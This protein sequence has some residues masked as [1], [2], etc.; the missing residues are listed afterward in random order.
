MLLAP[1]ISTDRL[2]IHQAVDLYA[3]H[4]S[5]SW[6][7]NMHYTQGQD[8][9]GPEVEEDEAQCP[10]AYCTIII[11]DQLVYRTRTKPLSNK[12]FFNAN[13]ERFVR[14]WRT[15]VCMV[16]VRD[17]RTREHDA[18][19][20]IV[21][22][23]LSEV[24]KN[25]S[26]VTK[27]YP[28]IGGVGEAKVRI[29]L[30][31]ESIDHTLDKKLLGWDVGNLRVTSDRFEALAHDGDCR[32]LKN[33]TLKMFTSL[34]S[35][36]VSR[37]LSH[38]Q[39]DVVYWNT[40]MAEN[41]HFELPIINRHSSALCI[42][43][44][45]TAR[46]SAYAISVLWLTEI[47]DNQKN[48]IKIPIWR[49]DTDQKRYQV[50]QNRVHGDQNIHDMKQIGY[51][52]FDAIFLRGLGAS[53]GKQ[54]SNDPNLRHVHECW[55]ATIAHGQRE[56]D[57][58]FLVGH[59]KD[60]NNKK[61]T[62]NIGADPYSQLNNEALDR[63]ARE[64][65]SRNDKSH[66]CDVE[67]QSTEVDQEG[68]RITEDTTRWAIAEIDT[69]EGIAHRAPSNTYSPITA[70]RRSDLPPNQRRSEDLA[71]MKPKDASGIDRPRPNSMYA[72]IGQNE[73][74]Q[75]QAM[76]DRWN[77][78]WLTENRMGSPISDDVKQSRYGSVVFRGPNTRH[79]SVLPDSISRSSSSS[80]ST[81]DA[82]SSSVRDVEKD[83]TVEQRRGK[84]DK[85]AEKRELHRQQRGSM[86]FK[87]MR[88]LKWAKDGVR[89][90]SAKFTDQFKMKSRQPDVQS[91]V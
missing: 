9:T 10:S 39:K 58:S 32:Q 61:R 36:K 89:L 8:T 2:E 60:K 6:K 74:T 70:T 17:S 84:R 82:A 40:G 35:M 77:N 68:R 59:K 55:Q 73:P 20:G 62:E 65:V 66:L 91:E 38:A 5:G 23:K 48:T 78:A 46:R 16:A 44:H 54:V 80:S 56:L 15:A 19:L 88:T 57:D 27:N 3:N 11:N 43:F 49:T 45:G 18:L 1:L 14:D 7:P 50:R 22:L 25:A 34:S 85:K 83:D 76:N 63:D 30:L 24:F 72:S 13:T 53:H 28:L 47:L 64:N 86:Q 29:S 42:E 4:P 37:R 71:S 41:E 12:P 90:G 52:Q 51:L 67:N 87:P 69:V 79:P 75:D 33:M 26:Q 21:P 31:W 81:D